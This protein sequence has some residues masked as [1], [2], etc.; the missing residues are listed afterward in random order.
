VGR[1]TSDPRKFSV[2]LSTSAD[3]YSDLIQ[4]QT[5]HAG[6]DEA[7]GEIRRLD[8][9]PILPVLLAAVE[10][11]DYERTSPLADSLISFFVRWT[12]IGR[13]E[14][15]LLEEYL[16]ALAKEIYTGTEIGEAILKLRAKAPQD[17]EFRRAFQSAVISRS[18]HQRHILERLERA[19]RTSKQWDELTVRPSSTVHIEHIY[20]QTPTKELKL[21]AHDDW[22]N[23]IGNLSLLHKR[24]NSRIKNGSFPRKLDVYRS[25]EIIITQDI[26]R[27]PFWM[28]ESCGGMWSP[29]GIQARQ[30]DLADIAVE[31]WR[32]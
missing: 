9:A 15:T 7:L 31:A 1:P 18:G 5:G 16:Y 24:L 17:E 14:S 26:E 21:E 4:A 20:P 32:I 10:K 11:A 27:F 8:A 13:R 2:E 6:L 30:A 22:V 12:V 19:K 25:S 23:R 28:S 29:E 3:V